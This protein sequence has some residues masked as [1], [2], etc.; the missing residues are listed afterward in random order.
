MTLEIPDAVEKALGDTPDQARRRALECMV[1]EGY[2]ADKLSRGQVQQLLALGWWETEDLLARHKAYI[3]YTVEDLEA[4]RQTL[5][6]LTKQH[7]VL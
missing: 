4:D 2:K 6:K 5:A 3:H 7:S 1:I